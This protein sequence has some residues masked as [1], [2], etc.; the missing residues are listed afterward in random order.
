MKRI[1]VAEFIGEL[2]NEHVAAVQPGGGE[3]HALA[4]KSLVRRLPIE[5]AEQSAEV[6]RIDLARCREVFERAD[7]LC[8]R[9]NRPA[10]ALVRLKCG[11]AADLDVNH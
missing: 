2:L 9:V 7:R 11:Q 10:A 5:P 1:R 4:E 3:I 6:R 8:I